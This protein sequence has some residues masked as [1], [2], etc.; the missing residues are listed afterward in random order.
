MRALKLAAGLSLAL[1]VHLALAMF[2]PAAGRVFD[3]FLLLIVL[4]ALGGNLLVGMF[5]GAAVGLVEDAFTGGLYGLHGF[6]GT[7]VGYT[8]ARAAQVLTLQKLYFVGL[9]FAAATLLQQLV[10]NALLLV[11]V[12][13]PELP[14][15]SSLAVG[16]LVGGVAGAVLVLAVERSNVAF[17]RWR[18]A[19]RPRVSLE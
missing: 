8:V 7:L 10:L 3:P 6:A 19:R 4:H 14:T 16:M 11:L 17:E 13:R 5:A 18:R 2:A 15:P 9:I 1:I 12:E